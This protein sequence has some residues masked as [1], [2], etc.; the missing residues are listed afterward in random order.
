MSNPEDPALEQ[1][2]RMM[3]E[4]NHPSLKALNGG[5]ALLGL[6]AGLLCPGLG[7][8]LAGYYVRAIVW[9]VLVCGLIGAVLFAFMHPPY[10][11]MLPVL[12]PMAIMVALCHLVDAAVC[13][14]RSRTS[15]LGETSI[16]YITALSMGG[17][18][19][20]L[21][22]QAIGYVLTECF[23]ICYT[24]TTSMVP[25]IGTDDWFLDRRG[26]PFTRWD[27]VVAISP[28]PKYPQIFKR[29]VGLPGDKVEI[30][31]DGVLINDTL[32]KLPDGVD[33]YLPMDQQGE[34]LEGPSSSAAYGCWGNPITLG[35]DEY[36][37]L[38][39]NSAISED[40]RFLGSI[41]DHQ[42][43]AMPRDQIMARVTAIVWPPS[44]WRV[45]PSPTDTPTR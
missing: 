41:E 38:G 2:L 14:K 28:D 4:K 18:A 15:M 27:L 42:P 29:V 25:T 36:F 26:A 11:P 34:I 8:L 22:R 12:V 1:A 33:K 9:F 45:F 16:R 19:F 23:E 30:T 17:L 32:V 43:G 24:P 21:Q 40:S 44:R 31:G 7:H 3:A 6:C 10:I 39:D 37:L 13:G 20:F 35:P 5:K